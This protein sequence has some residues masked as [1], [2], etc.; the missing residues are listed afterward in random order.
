M[1]RRVITTL[2]LTEDEA[3]AVAKR[4]DDLGIEVEGFS[5]LVGLEAT[6]ERFPDQPR[7]Q[8]MIR[9]EGSNALG[10]DSVELKDAKKFGE[11]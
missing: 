1:T 8:I 10:G 5:M 4:I 9:S 11:G 6:V 7:I 2:D 3:R